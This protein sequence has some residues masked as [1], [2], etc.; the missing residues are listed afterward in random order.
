MSLASVSVVVCTHNGACRLGPTLL[1]LAKQDA[2]ADCFI[3]VIV[4]DNASADE[5]GAAARAAWPNEARIPLRVVPESK[6]GLTY[7]RA[8]GWQTARGSI[9]VFVDD[10]NWLPPH[11]VSTVAHVMTVHPE[12][13]VCGGPAVPVF[14]ST[15]PAWFERYQEN[16][17]VGTQAGTS[18]DVT[19]IRPVLWGAG[20]AVRRDHLEALWQSGFRPW[21]SDRTGSRLAAGGDTELCLALVRSGGRVW[22]DERLA[23]QHFLPAGRLRWDHLRGLYRG[24][25]AATVVTDLYRFDTFLRSDP[26]RNFIRTNWAYR[27]L[28]TF[29]ELWSRPAALRRWLQANEGSPEVLWVDQQLGRLR[30]LAFWR[31]RYASALRTMAHRRWPTLR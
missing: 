9:V 6:L 24:F 5:S 17:A 13:S 14:E 12:V 31:A 15:P 3:E 22:Y 25:G 11:W 29:A 10:D 26:I 21:S 19:A 16:F 30:E 20:L 2:A 7:A 8:R 27:W 1:H 28:R 4:V 18:G 23:L